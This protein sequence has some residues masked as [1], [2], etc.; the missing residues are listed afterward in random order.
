MESTQVSGECRAETGESGCCVTCAPAPA[1]ETTPAALSVTH[2]VERGGDLPALPGRVEMTGEAS[3][4]MLALVRRFCAGDR[5]AGEKLPRVDA[6]F[7]PAALYPYRDAAKVR[8]DYPL[9]LSAD[10]EGV[11]T[12]TPI[13]DCLTS[14]A[15][16]VAPEADQGR[17]LKDNLLRLEQEV[18]SLC[19]GKT[20]ASPASE[21][22]EAASR[23]LEQKLALKGESGRQLHMDLA[24]LVKTVPGGALLLPMSEQAALEM[25]LFAARGVTQARSKALAGSVKSL[26]GR[27]RDLLALERGKG[28]KAGGKRGWRGP[29]AERGI[30]S[31]PV[32]WLACWIARCRSRRPTPRAASAW[33]A[34]WANW[35]SS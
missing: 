7:L 5:E 6:S 22:L 25:Y 1:A 3:A 2:G 28:A 4:E 29:W 20:G 8:S 32:R 10:A 35:T 16:A 23:L 21:T 15:A 14:L 11:A 24:A 18:R 9:L 13:A 26:R 34:C 19:A 33:S 17:V 31:M 27:L 12:C 30:A